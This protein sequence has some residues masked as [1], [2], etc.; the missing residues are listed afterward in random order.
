M[1]SVVDVWAWAASVVQPLAL[2]I[3]TGNLAHYAAIMEAKMGVPI[4]FWLR[5]VI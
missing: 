5:I 2:T 4:H 1:Y 3:N